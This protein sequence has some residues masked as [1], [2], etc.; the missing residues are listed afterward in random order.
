M[1]DGESAAAYSRIP[2][3]ECWLLGS[4]SRDPDDLPALIL[5]PKD[6]G[7]DYYFYSFAGIRVP[8]DK[9]E[10]SHGIG[11]SIPFLWELI[12]CTLFVGLFK[13]GRIQR[14]SR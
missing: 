4:L 13:Y 11:N 10:G 5:A 2:H 14:R 12:A 3:P 6:L 9:P 1:H 8:K 7:A